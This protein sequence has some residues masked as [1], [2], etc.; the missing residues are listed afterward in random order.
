LSKETAKAIIEAKADYLLRVKE[1]QSHLKESIAD[2]I[3]DEQ[4]RS[5]IDS[6]S[7]IEKQSGRIEKRNAFVTNDINM[8]YEKSKWPGL[9]CVGGI[10]TQFTTPKGTSNGWH[11][12]IFTRKN[13][14][15]LNGHF[16]K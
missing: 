12:Y 14:Q 2:Y 5:Q 6:F 10:N 16:L 4:L 1:N 9:V 7:T 3:S 13:I 15:S 11:Y 8:L